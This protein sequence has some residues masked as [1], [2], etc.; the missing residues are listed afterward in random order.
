MRRKRESHHR[1]TLAVLFAVLAFQPFR[2][3]AN[4]GVRSRLHSESQ[5]GTQR[6][7]RGTIVFTG[8]SSIAYWDTLPDDMKP[9]NVV[10]SAFGGAQYTELVDGV[11]DLVIFYHPVAL[12]VYAGDNDL[13]TPSRKTPQSVAGEVR[14]FVDLVHAKLPNTWIYVL[15]IKPSPARWHAW[16][17]MKEC[18]RLMEAFLRT[19][20]RTRFVDIASPLFDANG[21]LGRDL[22][23]QDGL[24][25][26]A[27]CYAMWTA[28]IKPILLKRFGDKNAVQAPGSN[29]ATDPASAV[30]QGGFLGI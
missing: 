2:A 11:D 4:D 28:I 9:L 27:K 13:V 15:S 7:A 25:P 14:H 22:F 16:P 5:T 3:L 10:N 30:L 21:E 26:S 29:R 6:A 19:Q 20:N 1:F 8:S 12:V 24:H 18:N 23:I 17:K